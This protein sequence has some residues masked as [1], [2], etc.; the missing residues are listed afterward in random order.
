MLQALTTPVWRS[1]VVGMLL[2]GVTVTAAV[3]TRDRSVTRRLRL[4]AVDEPNAIYLTMFR[5]GDLSV[6]FP[7]ADLRTL[8]FHVRASVYDGCRWLG[9][10]T[11]VPIDDRTF[12]YDYAETILGC[13]PGAQPLRKTPRQ[14]LVTVED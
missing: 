12:A 7:D 4:H 13:E 2:L 3:A 6:R 14:G 9:T 5:D 8:T 10:E 11:L 1:V